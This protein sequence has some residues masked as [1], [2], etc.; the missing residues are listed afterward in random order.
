RAESS[1]QSF[2]AGWEDLKKRIA[3]DRKKPQLWNGEDGVTVSRAI[4]A[5]NFNNEDLDRITSLIR[6]VGAGY[7]YDDGDA[8]HLKQEIVLVDLRSPTSQI[9]MPAPRTRMA[10]LSTPRRSLGLP[11]LSLPSAAP[12]QARTAAEVLP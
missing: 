4:I 5:Q 12:A 6:E 11:L 3:T 1:S 8:D 9:I 7:I 10:P 2:R